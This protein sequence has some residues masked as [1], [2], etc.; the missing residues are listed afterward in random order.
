[1]MSGGRTSHRLFQI[2]HLTDHVYHVR[3]LE[4]GISCHQ[5]IGTG[6]N[7][8]RSGLQVDTSVDFNQGL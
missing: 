3:S 2:L 4:Y 8:L 5:H 7:Q 1:M 6:L